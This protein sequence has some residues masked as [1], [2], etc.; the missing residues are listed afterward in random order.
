MT[1]R[2]PRVSE[3]KKVTIRHV[4]RVQ[5]HYGNKH[6]SWSRLA[7]KCCVP[8][9]QIWVNFFRWVVVRLVQSNMTLYVTPYEVYVKRCAR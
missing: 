2:L 3:Y 4:R 7:W 1:H 8:N 9:Q 5:P 6:R